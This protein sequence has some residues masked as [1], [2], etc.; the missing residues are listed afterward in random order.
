MTRPSSRYVCSACSHPEVRWLG[1]CPACGAWNSLQQAQDGAGAA[2]RSF[3][4][5]LESDGQTVEAV[6]LAEVDRDRLERLPVE[7]AEL[8]RV[9][10]GGLVR[11]SLLLCGGA[12]GVGKSTLLTMLAGQ[13]AGAGHRVV[14]LCAEEAAAQVR[15]RAE[16]VGAAT[17]GFLLLE[18]PALE[19]VLP[20]LYERPPSLLVV[21]SI[22][23]V[24]TQQI[25]GI[26]GSV[27]QIRFCGGLL[28]D[29][30][31]STG[32][33]VALIGHV[34][35][36]GDLAG[37]RLLEHMVD[38]VLYFEPEAGG[39]VRLVRAFK[40]R[41]GATG[42]LAVLEMGP[43]GLAPVRDA[44]ALFLAGRRSD[45]PG[46]AVTAIMS[47]SRPF[48]VEVQA[49]LAKTQY[50]TPARVVSGLDSKR[51]ALLSAILE[52]RGGLELVA[53]D[54]FVK[55]AGGLRLTDP[56]ADLAVVAAMASSVR[57][58]PLPATVV[59]IGEVGLTGELRPVPALGAR[60]TEARA[61]GFTRA[62]V[63]A[64]DARALPQISGM[65]VEPVRTLVKGLAAAFGLGTV[66]E[67]REEN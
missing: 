60:L 39:A 33:A 9:L 36:E 7:P 37:P 30:A 61:H 17:E 2:P 4:R 1:R 63:A 67:M 56:A 62:V 53:K 44:S 24:Y 26:P 59:A 41:F 46:S 20:P 64:P 49:L 29:F 28:C 58:R 25:D 45:E 47:G 50:A 6:P 10:G 51:V 34:T 15:R 8:A 40:N 12:P 16:R 48:L 13:L 66:R 23:A 19:R 65:A 18:E 22:Q 11:G 57:E 3:Q 27:S 5:R 31:R 21:D 55:V 32:C 52:R 35:K 42:E 38:T 14:Y 43:R 54:V